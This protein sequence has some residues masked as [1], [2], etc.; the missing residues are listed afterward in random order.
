VIRVGKANSSR[1]SRR[2]QF[3]FEESA[4]LDAGHLDDHSGVKRIKEVLHNLDQN[5][6]VTSTDFCL[7]TLD[8]VQQARLSIIKLGNDMHG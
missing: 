4:E 1:A 7:C 5:S 3:D 8:P 2:L 6:E